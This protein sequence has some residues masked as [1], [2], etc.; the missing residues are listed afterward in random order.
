MAQPTRLT[1]LVALV[2]IVYTSIL[3]E[4]RAG[5][6]PSGVHSRE[7]LDDGTLPQ[8]RFDEFVR[9]LADGD[10]IAPPSDDETPNDVFPLDSEHRTG[11][12]ASFQK[13]AG[14]RYCGPVL[15]D[16]LELVCGK[17]FL[18]MFG[19]RSAPSGTS[20]SLFSQ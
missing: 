15:A 14:G 12:V 18:S 11:E 7:P 13:R 3:S 17:N 6:M 16:V 1:C 9:A 20:R 2:C 10:A 8:T 4:T 19:K 5:T